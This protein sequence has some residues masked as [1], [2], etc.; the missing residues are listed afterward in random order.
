MKLLV[1]DFETY[2]DASFSLSRLSI[3]EYVHDPRFAVHGLAIRHPDGRIAF[4]R[5]VDAALLE[6]KAAYGDRLERV[7]TVMHNASFDAYVLH[8]R[9]GLSPLHLIDTMLLA[10]HVHGRRDHGQGADASLEA[11]AERY[12]LPGKESLDF[13]EGVRDPS[14]EQLAQ[15]TRYATRDV[16]ITAKL[17]GYLLPGVDRPQVEL[18]VM[19][20][21][22][23]I[24][25]EGRL[26]VDRAALLRL[27]I[28]IRR[29]VRVWLTEAV[30]QVARE[31]PDEVAELQKKNARVRAAKDPMASA[32]VYINSNIMFARLMERALSR[33]GRKV[34]T[35]KGKIGLIPALSKSDPEMQLLV[36]DEDPVV[37]SLAEARLG[38]KSADLLLSKLELLW[39]I[40]RAT[41]GFLPPM[42]VY[43]GSHTGR[44]SSVGFNIQNL[45][46]RGYGL[47]LRNL[48]VAGDGYELVV[49][50]LSQIEARIVAWIAEVAT[51]LEAFASGRDVYSDKSSEWF[52]TEVR[53]PRDS[54][55]EDRKRRLVA[56]REVGKAAILGLGYALGALKFL[57]QLR[58][59]PRLAPLF[60]D[61]TLNARKA[62]EIVTGFRESFWEIPHW[63]RRLECGFE[64]AHSGGSGWAGTIKFTREQNSVYLH[65][66]SGR[67]IR[68][69][70]VRRATSVNPREYLDDD[71]NVAIYAPEDPGLVYG[72]GDGIGIYGGLLMENLVQALARDLLVEAMLRIEHRCGPIAFHVHDEVVMR[73]RAESAAEVAE[74]VRE[75]LTRPPTWGNGLPLNCEIHRWSRYTK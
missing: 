16:E 42:L 62:K 57:A 54:D 4:R 74:I 39:R 2:F 60:A 32:L 3:P 51:L 49:A 36:E 5:D 59:E 63:W 13:L 45:G 12:R 30:A 34:P 22:V 47:K 43:F 11:L 19:Q 64:S 20:Q 35:K 1:L 27:Y 29:E 26:P 48:L 41:G 38:K 69:P 40:A 18:A 25:T 7:V 17:V 73:V 44:F 8:H 71:G 37:A 9:Y 65:L 53:K 46:K 70:N 28:E 58:K 50:D 15:L 6:L 24:F 52:R 72:A 68:Y 56:L 67:R 55:D 23:R 21:T 33:T 75:E 61:G 31:L 10:Y 66:P 14:V